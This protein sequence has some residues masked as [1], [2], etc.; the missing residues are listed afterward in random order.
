MSTPTTP[1]C[2]PGITRSFVKGWP[3]AASGAAGSARQRSIT[4]LGRKFQLVYEQAYAPGQKVQTAGSDLARTDNAV[5]S[6]CT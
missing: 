3:V 4:Q 6:T 1:P 5:G 2:V